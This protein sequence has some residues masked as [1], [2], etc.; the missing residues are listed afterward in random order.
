MRMDTRNPWQIYEELSSD[1]EERVYKAV[2]ARR[3]APRAQSRLIMNDIEVNDLA[4]LLEVLE[5]ERKQR[6]L[7]HVL[8]TFLPKR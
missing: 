6:R 5:Q 2:R 4:D 3:M 8:V 7:G 1:D